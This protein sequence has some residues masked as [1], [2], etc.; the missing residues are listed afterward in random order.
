MVFVRTEKSKIQRILDIN[1]GRIPF[2][3]T[4]PFSIR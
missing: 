4:D 1:I 2:P 3:S